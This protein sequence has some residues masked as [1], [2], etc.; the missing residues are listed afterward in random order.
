MNR[1]SKTIKALSSIIRNPWLLNKVL[2]DNH[3]W[4]RY[5]G[6]KYGI[7]S[8]PVVYPDKLF[9]NEEIVVSPYS[10]MEGGSLPTDLLLLK[11]LARSINSCA[12]FEIGTWRGESVANVASEAETC[13]TLDLSE[14]ELKSLGKPDQYISQQ[15][16]LSQGLANVTHLEGNSSSY[17][18]SQLNRK[19]DLVFIDGDHHY[20]SIVN[21]T[22]KVFG[23]LVHDE[24]IVVWH[25][26]AW[27]PVNVRYESMAAILDALPGEKHKD[28][29]HFGN[30]L[31][32]LYHPA[33]LGNIAE[34]LS[35]KPRKTFTLTI[36]TNT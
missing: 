13:F 6:K 24:S 34:Q 30:S 21:D 17:D 1:I 14:E 26:Y 19:F 35:I 15:R 8:L 36:G 18:F 3:R 27:D 31:S 5:V 20:G 4:E 22:K 29:Y 32:A 12:Y 11:G 33:G 23:H 10:F 2:D 25:D 28:L 9:S 16:I 7:S